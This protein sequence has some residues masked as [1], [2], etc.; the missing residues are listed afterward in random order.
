VSQETFDQF[1]KRNRELFLYLFLFQAYLEG[2]KL[3]FANVFVT[4]LA[5]LLKQ[6]EFHINAVRYETLDGFRKAELRQFIWKLKEAEAGF[7][8][9]YVQELIAQLQAFVRTDQDA[10][11]AI[12]QKTFAQG[13]ASAEEERKHDTHS[14]PMAAQDGGAL[15]KAIKTTPIAGTG[16]FPIESVNEM[17]LSHLKR[18]QQIV[19]RAYANGWK[20]QD[21][22]DKFSETFGIFDNQNSSVTATLLQHAHAITNLAVGSVFLGAY[23]WCSILDAHT[24][25]FCI[26][27]NGRVYANGKGPVPPG[28]WGCRAHTMPVDISQA[29]VDMPTRAAYVG[30]LAVSIQD[31]IKGISVTRALTDEQFRA[32]INSFLQ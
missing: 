5:S 30:T 8:S 17:A 25:D 16:L 13:I 10:A 1:E 2:V 14:G 29:A 12:Y 11:T 15:W 27:H 6:F 3:R 26:E 18:T 4:R 23:M 28:H 19:Q 7:Y 20:K 22:I 32:K 31:Q 21:L 9:S 24:T